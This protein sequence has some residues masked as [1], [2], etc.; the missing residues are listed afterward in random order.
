MSS[1]RACHARILWVKTSSG[2]SMPLDAVPTS[3]GNVLLDDEGIA[4]VQG[5]S[6]SLFPGDTLYMPHHATCPNVEE[7]RKAR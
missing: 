3:D 2:R 1:C 4:H 5:Q 7:F 6:S